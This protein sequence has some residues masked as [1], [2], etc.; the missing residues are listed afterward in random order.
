MRV[1]FIKDKIIGYCEAHTMIVFSEPLDL[2]LKQPLV[3]HWQKRWRDF[4]EF[5][6]KLRLDISAG[7]DKKTFPP[8]WFS[9]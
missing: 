3:S 4:S 5:G 2:I 8:C 9:V 7:S 1:D 6:K